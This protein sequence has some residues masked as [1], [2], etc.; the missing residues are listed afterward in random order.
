LIQISAPVDA[1]RHPCG[2]DDRAKLLH[3][4]ITLYRHYL[5]DGVPAPQAALYL[6][7]IQRDETELKVIADEGEK[8]GAPP[9]PDL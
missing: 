7:Q 5:R 3:R 1:L 4:R 9:K 2:M 6:K 8:N